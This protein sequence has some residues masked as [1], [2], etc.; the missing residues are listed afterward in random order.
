MTDNLA[1]V[2]EPAPATRIASAKRA[3]AIESDGLQE[4]IG[5]LD[6]ELGRNFESA[7]ELMR[8]ARGRIILTG[9]GKSGHIARKIA[10]TLASTGTPAIFVHPAEASHGDLGM[11][12]HDDV[13]VMISNSGE[14]LELKDILAYSRRFK[15]PL[16]AIT[17]KAASTVATESDVALVLPKAREACPIGLAPTT[18]T[19]LQLA[20]GD[21]LAIAL[22]EDKGFSARDFHMFHPGG[23]L[24]AA[25]TH[26]RDIMHKAPLLPLVPPDMP[27]SAALVVMTEKSL[28][29]LGVVDEA[30]QLIGIITDGDLRRHMS[31]DLVDLSA[32]SVMTTAPRTIDPGALASE[33]LEQLN[34]R[35]I[36]SL[37]VV[38]EESRPIGLIHIHDLLRLG[39]S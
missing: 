7:V 20:L 34:S 5:E 2:V 27:M 24:G 28:G 25:L 6:G 19:L 17:S 1:R 13:I 3:L 39:V 36:T 26:V 33:A 31:R 12:A 9:I 38:D 22:L 23:R 30:G 35:K 29:C 15:V 16:V 11:I 8:N 18:S 32:A 21:A 10:A 14:S 37:F 4:L